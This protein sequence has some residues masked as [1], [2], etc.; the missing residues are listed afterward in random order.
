MGG[1]SRRLV[2]VFISQPDCPLPSL[3]LPYVLFPPS[4]SPA[5]CCFLLPSPSGEFVFYPLGW[6]VSGGAMIPTTLSFINGPKAE[7]RR[8][9]RPSIDRYE[10]E[11]FAT[12]F[13]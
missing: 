5:L 13:I 3:L 8:R 1:M 9:E 7:T 4:L 6:R 10:R 11:R 2:C 12:F